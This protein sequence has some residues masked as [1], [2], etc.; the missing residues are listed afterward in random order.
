MTT[1][2]L[3]GRQRATPEDPNFPAMLAKAHADKTRPLCACRQPGIA[4]Y[5][6]KLGE[7]HLIKRMPSSGA[8]HHPDCHSFEPP[9]ELSGLGQVAGSAIQEDVDSGT[10]TLKLDFSLS[11]VGGRTAP[12]AKGGE[13]DSVRTDGAKLTLRGTLHF[14][15]EESALN[16]WTPAMEGKRS[17]YVVRKALLQAAL[18]KDAKGTALDS[19]LFVPETFSVER[20]DEIERRRLAKLSRVSAPTPTGGARK[21]MIL[22]GEV[23]EISPARYGQKL[24]VKHLPAMHFMLDDELHQRLAK[25][26]AD[27]LALWNADE[28]THLVVVATFGIG[29]SGFAAIEEIALMVTAPNWIPVE[30]GAEAQLVGQLVREGRRF[31]KGLRYNLP[32]TKPLASAVLTDTAPKPVALYVMPLGAS[33]DFRDAMGD[34]IDASDFPPWLWKPESEPLLP[35]PALKDYEAMQIM[36]GAAD[37][38]ASEEADE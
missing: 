17:W 9:A 25:R 5:V 1:T 3:F 26:F 8:D 16:R 32:R 36:L 19:V 24:V 35:L 6:A 34:L 15:W 18:Q 13:A 10:T 31:T 33:D 2:Y 38:D 30:H 21:L 4:M 37:P 11:K 28:T 14:L 12:V 29:P 20:K 27:E 7:R 23:K 22:I